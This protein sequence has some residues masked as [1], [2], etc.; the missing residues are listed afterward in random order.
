MLGRL[1]VQQLLDKGI[2]VRVLRRSASP[3]ASVLNSAQFETVI[4]DLTHPGSLRGACDGIDAVISCAGASMDM[5]RFSDRTS[6]MTVDLH[7]NSALLKEAV[8]AGVKK[9]VYVSVGGEG[10]Y[11]TTEYVRAHHVFEEHLTASGLPYSIVRPAGFFAFLAE[12][13]AMARK[14]RGFL[15]GDG[16]CRTNPVH[17]RE[18]AQ[19][20]VAAL[21][22]QET[23]VNAGGPEIFTRRQIVEL[24]FAVAGRTPSIV[25]VP[26]A[27]FSA[28]TAPMRL[29]NPR[30]HALLAFGAAVS[31]A[32][33]V[34]PVYGKERLEE[35]FRALPGTNV[36]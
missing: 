6:F 10:P 36:P 2:S 25:S 1:V 4:A 29:F 5:K 17:E 28:M 14:G 8:R 24:A 32:D 22:T 26:P 11:R 15:I 13:A 19:T 23:V 30:I 3:A 34:V 20:C 12:I 16:H 7:G 27:V 31:T 21:H 9:F 33:A 35:Y 18:V